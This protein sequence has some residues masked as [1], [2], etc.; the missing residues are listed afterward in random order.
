MQKLEDQVKSFLIMG[1][2][3]I[4]TF[5]SLP[6][7]ETINTGI[8]LIKEEFENKL[9]PTIQRFRQENAM[10]VSNVKR[11]ELIAKIADAFGDL[12]YVTTCNCVAWGFP[13]EKILE[14]IQKSNMS[15]VKVP[16]EKSIGKKFDKPEGWSPPDI[17]KI[18]NSLIHK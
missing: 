14:E 5:P 12:L 10:G 4:G 2:Q 11:I 9:I 1:N 13:M 8:E 18:L 15:K 7:D 16:Y 17:P 3:P 6:T